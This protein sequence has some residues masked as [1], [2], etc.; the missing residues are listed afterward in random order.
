MEQERN[1]VSVCQAGWTWLRHRGKKTL[2]LSIMHTK[3]QSSRFYSILLAIAAGLAAGL[4]D[5]GSSKLFQLAL[6][7]P[8][9]M[10]TVFSFA[11]MLLWGLPSALV[12]QALLAGLTSV[13]AYIQHGSTEMAWVYFFCGAAIIAVLRLLFPKGKT[14][15]MDEIRI[16]T[17][18]FMAVLLTIVVGSII[19]G[20]L[21]YIIYAQNLHPAA[22][23]SVGMVFA[24]QDMNLLL[25][26][27]IGHIPAI[28]ADR[29]LATYS[30]YGLYMI[31]SW[32]KKAR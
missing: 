9:F 7:L 1:F 12:A 24:G 6:R 10:D 11:V 23:A 15:T 8:V 25:S 5:Y 26:F 19:G 30:G 21:Q 32:L 16:L 22:A 31:A 20:A 27:I 28:A 3:I 14:E 4:L 18:L 17:R 29:L 13:V 2:E